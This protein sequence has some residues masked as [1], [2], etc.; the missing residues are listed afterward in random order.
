MRSTLA[1]VALALA[2]TA[3]T[4]AGPPPPDFQ[5]TL[6]AIRIELTGMA[7]AAMPIPIATPTP[8][9]P[10]STATDTP[11]PTA[12]ATDTPV[13]TATTTPTPS[14]EPT[15]TPVLYVVQQGDYPGLIASRFGVSVEEL[16]E[17]N[18]ITNP[19]A[20]AIGQVLIIP[21]PQVTVTPESQ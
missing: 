18:G 14:P 2:L 16:M 19:R 3:C 10:T 12:T 20:L 21:G 4:R 1:C 13:P 15:A 6:E 9:V 17:V 7:S 8:A 5:S 11:E